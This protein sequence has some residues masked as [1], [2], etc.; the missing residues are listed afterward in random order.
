MKTAM[1]QYL[2]V[3]QKPGERPQYSD[4]SP[5]AGERL[6]LLRPGVELDMHVL[7]SFW[8]EVEAAESR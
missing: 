8:L 5:K 6:W 7:R 2:L 1:V 4:V 3:D